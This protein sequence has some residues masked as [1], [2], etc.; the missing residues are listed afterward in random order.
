MY[1]RVNLSHTR[2]YLRVYKEGIS[3]IPG[4]T[5]G[6]IRV[7]LSHTRVYLRVCRGCTSLIPWYTAGCTMVYIPP[8]Y[9]PGCTT[10][11]MPPCVCVRCVQRCIC[12][13]V[14]EGYLCADIYASLCFPFHC[15]VYSRS[16]CAQVLS[17][18]GLCAIPDPFHCWSVIP[19]SL[20]GTPSRLLSRFTVGH[21]ST[22]LRLDPC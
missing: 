7:Y 13:P 17:V 5:S 10:V 6:C 18:A 9:T 19:V 14:W 4:Y 22:S 21:T 8:R 2:V 11:Y 3:H 15:W 1:N 20:V 16:P 12:L